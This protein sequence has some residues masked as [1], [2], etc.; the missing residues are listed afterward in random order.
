MWWVATGFGLLG[1]RTT[2]VLCYH[3]VRDT[4][5]AAF[6]RQM[7]AIASRCVANVHRTA[8][9][10]RV[11]LPRVAVTFDDA[12]ECLDR[13]A[14][15][16]L[17]S[18]RVEAGVYAVTGNAGR[19]PEWD[20]AADHPE[21]TERTMTDDELKA[22]ERSSAFRLGSH[23]VSHPRLADLSE[24][25]IR[26][27]LAGSRAAL[28][29][30]LGREVDELAL[31]HGSYDPRVLRLAED[32]GYRTVYALGQAA[33]QANPGICVPRCSMSPD[34]WPI[35]F[36]LTTRGAYGWLPAFRGLIRSLRRAGAPA[37][38]VGRG[39]TA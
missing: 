37:E 28:E 11:G 33:S 4:Q 30:L 12:F 1:R 35:E 5:R 23:T 19:P 39:V 2:I 3:A 25:E 7:A 32:A 13:N 24:E 31:P 26:R 18:L 8:S 36:F 22:A 10:H 17:E 16:V 6:E 14:R 21:A 15:P 29:V 20:I 27:E 38:Q 9:P 34:V